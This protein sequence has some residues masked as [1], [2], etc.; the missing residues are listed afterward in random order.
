MKV[1]YIFILTLMFVNVF[2]FMFNELGMFDYTFSPG[3]A[4]NMTNTTEEELF[5]EVTGSQFGLITSLDIN[6]LLSIAG[7]VGITGVLSVFMHSPYPIAV[8]LFLATFINLYM[9]SNSILNTVDVNPYLSMAFGLG[10]VF[11]FVITIIEYFTHGD[12]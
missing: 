1:I 10:M 3:D 4:Y 9:N 8:G 5:E 6:S 2:A 7:I 11:L 12:V